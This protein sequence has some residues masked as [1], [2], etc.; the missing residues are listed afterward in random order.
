MEVVLFYAFVHISGSQSLCVLISFHFFQILFDCWLETLYFIYCLQLEV[1][2]ATCS[3]SLFA[4]H[5]NIAFLL[6]QF[7]SYSFHVHEAIKLYFSLIFLRRKL[8]I[9]SARPN[10]S[11]QD[12]VVIQVKL[13]QVR[14][15]SPLDFTWSPLLPL[16][17]PAPQLP[18]IH[19][20]AST[21]ICLDLHRSSSSLHVLRD[22]ALTIAGAAEAMIWASM[23]TAQF[24]TTTKLCELL[25]WECWLK[26]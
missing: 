6:L 7:F 13:A 23:I 1:G 10:W 8:L 18:T 22:V 4:R 16:F 26:R 24:A 5:T 2:R 17:P 12:E 3:W 14:K 9:K 21:T 15:S 25:K 11:V 19:F 20:S